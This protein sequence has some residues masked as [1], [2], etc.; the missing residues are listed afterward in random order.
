MCQQSPAGYLGQVHGVV[1]RLCGDDALGDTPS[2]L[3]SGLQSFLR[4]L[5]YELL[6]FRKRTNDELH[7]Q[8][9]SRLVV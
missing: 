7:S 3:T 1:S 2:L 6:L 9:V 4:A 8:L 5:G